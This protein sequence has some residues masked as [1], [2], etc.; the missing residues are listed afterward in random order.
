MPVIYIYISVYIMLYGTF[1]L[2]GPLLY[3]IISLYICKQWWKLG[4]FSGG[5]GASV[6]GTYPIR[7][8]EYAPDKK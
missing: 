1:F 6:E 3:L 7:G 4:Q 5:G 2:Y 8:L